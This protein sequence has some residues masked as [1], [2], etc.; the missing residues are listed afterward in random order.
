MLNEYRKNIWQTR[1]SFNRSYSLYILYARENSK[2]LV[3]LP[4]QITMNA[5]LV[6][7]TVMIMQHV[8]IPRDHLHAHVM[9]AI[10][11]MERYV[12][13]KDTLLFHYSSA[14]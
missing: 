9:L 7:T 1:N 8:R 4:F 14:H 12:T 6:L 3:V 11:E 13:V 5:Y 10:Q 2:F